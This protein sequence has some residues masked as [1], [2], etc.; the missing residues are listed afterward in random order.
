M[1]EEYKQRYRLKIGFLPTRRRVFSEEEAGKYKRLVE[2]KVRTYDADLVNLDFLNREGLIYDGLDADKAADRFIDEKVDALFA[3]HCNFGTED[4]VAKV[5]KK[6][7]KPLLLWGPQDDVWTPDGIRMRDTQCGLFATSKALS[8]LGVPFT[9]VTNSPINSETFDRGYRNFLSVAAVVKAFRRMRIGQIDTRPAAFWSVMCSESEL[10]EKFGIEVV[11]ISLAAIEH[12]VYKVI[13]ENDPQY[14]RI[15]ETYTQKYHSITTAE[16]AL[17]CLAA[18]QLVI[19]R[20]AHAEQL[21]AVC[22]QCWDALQKA[23][24]VFPCFVNSELTDEGLPVACETDVMG[25]VS[26]VMLQAAVRGATPAFLADLTV[27]HPDN[28]NAEL[29]WHCGN[30]PYSLA[31]YPERAKVE[32]Q[33]GGKCPAAGRWELK[34]GD[35][36]ICK[37]D[38]IGG[39]YS[40]LMGECRGTDGPANAG[41]YIW[42]EFGDWPKWEHRL[43]YGPYIHHVAAVH[44]RVAAALYE[45][46]KYIPGLTPDPVEP[47]QEEIEKFLR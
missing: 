20:W 46:C 14:L 41:T 6:V 2:E 7:N 29:L 24:G 31:R 3:P 8:R 35:I 11:P 15:I 33:Y 47:S 45:A 27:R 23:L 37:M 22:I 19:R 28:P 40:L 1:L 10:L 36:T 17:K 25:A 43:I 18:L 32:D 5:A 21:S 12:D 9:Y 16:N 4:A 34:G 30:F 26:A 42:A 13:K 38:G 44:G 39:R